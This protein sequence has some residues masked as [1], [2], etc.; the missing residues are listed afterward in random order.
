MVPSGRRRY[1]LA[2]VSAPAQPRTE[3]DRRQQTGCVGQI[4]RDRS[5]Y[6][7]AHVIERH[8]RLRQVE[9]RLLDRRPRRIAVLQSDLASPLGTVEAD[10]GGSDDPA[11]P[12]DGDVNRLGRPV[13]KPL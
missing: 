12:G 3:L 11:L 13:R 2:Q 1:E 4:P 9:Y 10:A 8:C 6:P 7:S 5:R